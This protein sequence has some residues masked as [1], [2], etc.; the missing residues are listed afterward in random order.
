MKFDSLAAEWKG[1]Y[2]PHLSLHYY[3]CVG[4]VK[5]NCDVTTKNNI[6]SSKHQH[7]FDNLLLKNFQVCYHCIIGKMSCMDYKDQSRYQ[8]KNV[9]NRKKPDTPIEQ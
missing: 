5:G 1:F 3:V 4:T 2:H 7:V 8:T 6:D 9:G